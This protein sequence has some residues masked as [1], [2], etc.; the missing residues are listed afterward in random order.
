MGGGAGGP[1]V[2]PECAQSADC[3]LHSDCCVCAALASGQAPPSCNLTCLDN[4]C[5]STT[6][7]KCVFGQ[8]STDLVCDKSKVSPA[9][10]PVTPTP[11]CPKGLVVS[12][13]THSGCWGPCLDPADCLSVPYCNLCRASQV[14]VEYYDQGKLARRRCVDVPPAC[15]A[16]RDCSCMGPRVCAGSQATCSS[17]GTVLHCAFNG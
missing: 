7:P 14:C 5:T 8:C 9:C 16:Q 10:S 12:V 6:H 1:S 17:T 2:G 4:K 13:D 11:I 15:Q 3:Q